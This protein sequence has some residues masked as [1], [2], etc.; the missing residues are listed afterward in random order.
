VVAGEGFFPVLVIVGSLA[1]HFLAH[2]RNPEDL[3]NEV[4]H[5]FGPRQPA[6]IPVN[7][8][9]V[10]AVIYKNQQAAKQP[11]ESLHRSTSS[12]EW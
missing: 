3:T 5:L 10:E 1:E 8:N 12:E 7:D 2:H 4:D 9:A 11:C 6:E